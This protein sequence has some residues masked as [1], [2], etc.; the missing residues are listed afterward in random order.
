LAVS[1]RPNL[2][3][4]FTLTIS[5]LLAL[6]TVTLGWI[7]LVQ[8][9]ESALRG[10][11]EKGAIVAKGLA[12]GSELGVFTHNAGLLELVLGPL[13]DQTDVVY[14][15]VADE[16]GAILAEH[17]T[18]AVPA[19]PD[20]GRAALSLPR[21]SGAASRAL[22]EDADRDGAVI[23][24][25]GV[26][27]QAGRRVPIGE[28]MGMF[29]AAD[30]TAPRRGSIGAIC[31]GISSAGVLKE[32]RALRRGL[33][34]ATLAVLLVGLAIAVLMVRVI[35]EPVKD[36]VHATE[37]IAA[38]DL[39]VSLPRPGRDEIGALAES[40]NQMTINLRESRLALESSNAD[41]EK[42]VQERTRALQ[43]AQNQ[44]IQAEKMSV[45]GQL[46][47]GVAHELNNPLAGVLGY[48]QLL[49]RKGV[50][51]EVGRGL[52]KIQAEAERCRRIVQNLLIFARKHK[53]RQSL[54][55]LNAVIESTLELRAYQLKV[56]NI[57]VVR[58][59]DPA[60]P[61]TMADMN[62]IQQVLMNMINNAQHALA[63]VGR[64]RQLI[65]RTRQ[66]AGRIQIQ[67]ADTGTGIAPE[68]LGR[69]FD[70][71]FTTKEVGRGT[72]LG[73]S[74]CYGIVQEHRGEI[75]VESTPGVG[76]TFT[77]DLPVQQEG[78]PAE[79]EAMS[80]TEALG[81]TPTRKGRILLVD[82]ERSILDVIGDVLRMDGHQV[83]TLTN[84]SAALGRLRQERFD[85]IVSDLKMPGMSG[86]ELFQRLKELD[87]AMT[88]RLVFTTGDLASPETLSFLESTGNRYLQ[89]PF[90]LN[91]VRRIVQEMLASN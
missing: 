49:A 7:F 60:L 75:Q 47:S 28:E 3:V 72:G 42:K 52:E 20:W 27:I 26:P 73:L 32:M 63:D 57:T 14:A 87:S 83:E 70:P 46:V 76:T 16:R 90:D 13:R 85:V 58:D 4:K 81:G 88:R 8:V 15:G 82:D 80:F 69:I 55:D 86:Q 30:A 23:Y 54:L 77:I 43:E 35:V 84:G 31:V 53:P 68:N 9:E 11:R 5:C 66:R 67:V 45:V 65:L 39:E 62:Q 10:L 17:R 1:F 29:P 6:T 91:A 64:V 71:F 41:L 24:Y 51:E 56:D 59:L 61:R 12:D 40:F 21:D 2:K 78:R 25:I 33:A 48:S 74:I 18:P 22:S 19:V 34:L 37:R 79:P 38:G 36:L 50:S 44:L 89:K